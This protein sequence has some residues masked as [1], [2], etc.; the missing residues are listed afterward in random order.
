M[1]IV[2]RMTIEMM[3]VYKMTGDKMTLDVMTVYQMSIE[4]MAKGKM[5]LDEMIVDKMTIHARIVCEILNLYAGFSSSCNCPKKYEFTTSCQLV[6]F[7]SRFLAV[8]EGQSMASSTVKKFT[9]VSY[10]C[11]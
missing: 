11:K 1:T 8:L 4:R 6:I 10:D 9:I 5:T 7:F 2:H 3:T